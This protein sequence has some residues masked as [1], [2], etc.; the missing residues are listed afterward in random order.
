VSY[1]VDLMVA[2]PEKEVFDW[3]TGGVSRV[4]LHIESFSKI[5][6]ISPIGV[7]KNIRERFGDPKESMMSVEI[8][9]AIGQE[10]PLEKLDSLIPLIDFVQIMGI[11]K[12]G[13]Q[14]EPFD[15]RTYERLRTLREKHPD[16][17][18]S[19]D[20]GVSA[21]NAGELIKAGA[22]RLV[23]G[24]YIFESDNVSKAIEILKN[25]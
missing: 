2:N 22:N 10:T 9:I 12:I 11:A 1:E 20:G 13:F 24:S 21:D 19:V 6:D 3:V 14:G 8:G 16:L 25:A 5:G 7:V 18:L 17:I 15:Q 4:I 23:S